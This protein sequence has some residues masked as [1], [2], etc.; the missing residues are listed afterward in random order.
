MDRI[1]GAAVA[2]I[3]GLL[4]LA[5]L[6]GAVSGAFGGNK[7]TTV[8]QDVTQLMT[9]ARAQ[10]SQGGS[11]YANFTTANSAALITAGIPPSGMV[12]GA[13]IFDAWGNPVTLAPAGGSAQGVVSFGGG[14][15]ETA[16]QCVTVV[17]SLK[18]YV[19]LTVN[20]T[21][22]T[23]AALPDP[24]AAAAACTDTASFVLTFQ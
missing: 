14:N 7:A 24:V 1:L 20:G 12:R 15:A 10:F 3:L 23:P 21:T 18:D 5:G 19:S 17:T 4:A 11:G 8:T 9:N 2:I 22:F 16:K 13:A 6:T